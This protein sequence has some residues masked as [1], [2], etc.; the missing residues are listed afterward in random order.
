MSKTSRRRKKVAPSTSEV[1]AT[2]AALT[3]ELPAD[4]GQEEKEKEKVEVVE[5]EEGVKT[6]T[7]DAL[8]EPEPE[9]SKKVV[10]VNDAMPVVLS[11]GAPDVHAKKYTATPAPAPRL[12]RV[13]AMVTQNVRYGC[14]V[15]KLKQGKYYSLPREVADWLRAGHRVG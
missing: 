3:E 13:R 11:D 2:E 8:P 6:V 1:E 7:D 12:D 10:P 9:S 5:A 14:K 4:A 15:Y